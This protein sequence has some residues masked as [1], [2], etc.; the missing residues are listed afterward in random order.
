VRDDGDHR[1]GIVAGEISTKAYVDIPSIARQTIRTSA[2]TARRRLRRQ[3]LRRL[4]AI[5]E[6]S[7]DIAQG[8]DDSEEV[9]SGTAG[10]DDSS[11]S[12]V[13]ATRG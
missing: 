9:R 7:P 12:R 8:V 4:V 11:T 3:H 13:R 2:T 1:P 5:D 10:E 6:Q